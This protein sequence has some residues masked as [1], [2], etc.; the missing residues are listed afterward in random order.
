MACGDVVSLESLQT[1]YKHQIFEAEVITGKAGGAA[2]GATIGTATNP[3]TG[4]T[5]QT[6]PSILA[7]LGFDVQSWT[8]STGG[9]L[10]SANQV[11]LNDTPGSLG[12]GDYY[13]WGG[14]F[15]KTVPAGTDPA[16]PTSG[17]IMRSSRFAGTQAREALRRSYAQAGYNLVD[18]SFEAGGTLVNA[19]DV[20][21]QERTGKAFTGPAGVVAAGT[22]PSSG[23]FV[24]VSAS[25]VSAKAVDVSRPADT[26]GST[27]PKRLDFYFKSAPINL[28]EALPS[29][30]V[31]DG[32]VD[33]STYVQKVCEYL[34]EY[35]G[36]RIIVPHNMKI[37]IGNINSY[38]NIEWFGNDWTSELIVKPSYYG[39]SVNAGTGGTASVDDN[40]R[41]C[42]FNGFR[43]RGQVET[44]GFSQQIHLLN[45]NAV[46][47]LTIQ[48]MSLMGAQG[49]H[50]Y[51]GSSNVGG[52]ERHNE[53]VTIDRLFVDGINKN[54]R[55]G[56]SVVD[57]DGLKITNS[58]FKRVT[59]SDMP[60][61]IDIEPNNYA[62]SVV[63]NITIEDVFV[64]DCG[65][66]AAVGVYVPPLPAAVSG[67]ATKIR[68]NRI[69]VKKAPNGAAAA[70]VV[71]RDVPR[72]SPGHGCS[73]TQIT[74]KDIK[75][76]FSIEGV[77]DGVI[78][79]CSF[80][81]ATEDALIGNTYKPVRDLTIEKL[82][83]NKCGTVSLG[84][85]KVVNALGLDL[86]DSKFVDCGNPVSGGDIRFGAGASERIKLMNNTHDNPGGGNSRVSSADVAHVFNPNTNQCIGN[87]YQGTKILS[88]FPAFRTDE[89]N[90]VQNVFS[91]NTP[92]NAFPQGRSTA[93]WNSPAGTLPPGYTQGVCV[94]DNVFSNIGITQVIT[95]TFTPRGNGTQLDTLY[96][97][98]SAD[99]LSWG[100]WRK[101]TAA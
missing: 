20:L 26:A 87:T 94:T 40:A 85:L 50:I 11:F 54:Q 24:D 41:N 90:G 67:N 80:E 52:V 36:G 21:L 4:Q 43:I 60:G 91:A 33:Y 48:G 8:S 101:V 65:G 92:P 56:V 71:R 77:V 81:D 76:P 9:V 35:G 93:L 78:Y 31:T 73:M 1:Q 74:G 70:I 16:L 55:N 69:D 7:D 53:D 82:S 23:G 10:A 72:Q 19:N 88:I 46:S 95:Q 61:A 58:R 15:P 96:R 63:K 5:Q 59:R 97:Y 18:G 64:D 27:F 28:T 89:T 34:R 84:A 2:G 39:I 29:S 99:G 79:D 75:H 6:L 13:A 66:V 37:L 51:L 68:F 38:A 12:L 22:N 3:V 100:A 14:T 57:C 86:E 98:A 49:D 62:F 45:L 44:A 25:L 83:L 47:A 30:Y 32:S 17:Y 42:V